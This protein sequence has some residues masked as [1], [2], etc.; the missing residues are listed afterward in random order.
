MADSVG[1]AFILK[2]SANLTLTS[3]ILQYGCQRGT[4]KLKLTYF[5]FEL[6][7]AALFQYG[8]LSGTYKIYVN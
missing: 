5:K 4:F 1:L 3:A 7:L 6:A 2:E 8:Y